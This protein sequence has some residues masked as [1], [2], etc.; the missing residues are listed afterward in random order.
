MTHIQE[1]YAYI[2]SSSV[3][4]KVLTALEKIPLRPRL[5]S[6]KLNYATSQISVALFQLE[7]KDMVKCLTP[8]KQSWRLYAITDTGKEVLKFKKRIEK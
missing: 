6:K 4:T 8:E 2:A 3:R 7:N 1:L 5:I